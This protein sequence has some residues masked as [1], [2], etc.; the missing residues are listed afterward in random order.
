MLL[1]AIPP[2]VI[3]MVVAIL[4]VASMPFASAFAAGPVSARTWTLSEAVE[5]AVRTSDAVVASQA[6]VDM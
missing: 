4:A 1:S 6:K 5:Q 3:W 2:F